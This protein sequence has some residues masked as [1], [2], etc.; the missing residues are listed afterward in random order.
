MDGELGNAERA[1]TAQAAQ[2][3][4]LIVSRDALADIERLHAFLA[5][6]NPA[7]AQRAVALISEAARSLED[8]PDRGRPS[9]IP[10][11]RE[12]IVPFGRSAYVLR[13]A[14]FPQAREIV[15]VRVWRSREERR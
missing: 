12:L 2:A 15:I 8:F 3:V 11:A 13:Y 10:G 14:H 5:K 4:K 6:T 1:S 7:L 9:D